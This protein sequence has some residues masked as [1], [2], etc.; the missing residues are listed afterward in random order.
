MGRGWGGMMIDVER[1]ASSI[2]HRREQF[3]PMALLPP[4]LGLFL[5]RPIWFGKAAPP[6]NSPH[7]RGVGRG[8][9]G[10]KARR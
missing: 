9:A 6:E 1:D 7:D 4:S 8:D 5:G 2:T 10:R 3:G